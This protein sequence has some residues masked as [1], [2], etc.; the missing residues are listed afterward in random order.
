MFGQIESCHLFFSSVVSNK[1][2][3]KK[4]EI[5]PMYR[6]LGLVLMAALM[7]GCQPQA[8]IKIGLPLLSEAPRDKIAGNDVEWKETVIEPVLDILAEPKDTTLITTEPVKIEMTTLNEDET[9]EPPTAVPET[10]EVG[11]TLVDDSSLKIASLAEPESEAEVVGDPVASLQDEFAKPDVALALPDEEIGK[12]QIIFIEPPKA[13]NPIHPQTIVG[14]S[15]DD[16]GTNLGLPDFERSDSDVVIWQ[17]RLAACVTDFY[18]Y[19]NGDEYVVTGWAWRP[20][21]INQM[22]DEESCQQQIGTL[23]DTNA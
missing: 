21:L 10:D 1:T 9:S 7:V 13:S 18:L 14:Q 11:L 16:L 12:E 3:Q 20:P 17:Y 4:R 6:F 19:Q 2:N 5:L 22:M 15:I 23:I 8:N